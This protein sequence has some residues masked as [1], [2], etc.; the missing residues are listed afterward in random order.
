MEEKKFQIQLL[1][2][3]W[4]G[5]QGEEENQN[6]K[7]AALHGLKISTNIKEGILISLQQIQLRSQ[8]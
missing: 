4:I 2:G 3:F 7:E 8:R 1:S 6:N 5:D